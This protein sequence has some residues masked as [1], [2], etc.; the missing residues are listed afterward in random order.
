MTKLRMMLAMMGMI[1]GRPFGI[2]MRN[3]KQVTQLLSDYID[4]ELEG[5]EKQNLDLHVMACPDCLHYLQTFR[6]TRKLVGE[7]RYE[8]IPGEFRKRLHS[9]LHE[10]LRDT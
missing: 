5:R 3:C 2:R 7:I 9:V 1:L 4:G 6:E 10:R 8:E